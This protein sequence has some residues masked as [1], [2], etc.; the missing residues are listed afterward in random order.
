MKPFRLYEAGSGGTQENFKFP[1][2]YNNAANMRTA[3][4]GF[5]LTGIWPFDRNVF[6]ETDFL[7]A[8]TKYLALRYLTRKHVDRITPAQ[9][10]RE[11]R[12]LVVQ[13]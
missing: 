1:V 5:R 2:F 4:K 9:L 7:P 10:H 6:S 13:L 3:L 11:P 12:Y 8:S